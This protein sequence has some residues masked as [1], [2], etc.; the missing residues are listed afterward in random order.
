M[1]LLAKSLLAAGLTV[2]ATAPSMMAAHS[3]QQPQLGPLENQVRH[4]LNML[5]YFSIFDNLAFHVDGNTVTL[6]GQ[7]TRPVLKSDALNV[8]RSI[9]GVERVNDQ[10]EV[11]PLSMFDNQTRRAE[12]R[13]IYGYGPLQRY[14]MGTHPSIHI[15]VKN[16]HVTLT[17]V[18]DN[19][20]DKTLAFMRANQVSGV[21]SVDNQLEIA[22]H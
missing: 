17:G 16:G 2:L 11:L 3:N 15:I 18:V 19:Q 8:V 1:K 7:V 21:F 9:P 13:A 10:V 22:G 20:M 5:P 12:A 14:S 4:E 6:I